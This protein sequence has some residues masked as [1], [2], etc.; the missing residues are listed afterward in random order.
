MGKAA[1]GQCRSASLTIKEKLPDTQAFIT[2]H[3][4]LKSTFKQVQKNIFP[5]KYAQLSF[6]FQIQ[7]GV[8]QIAQHSS[9]CTHSGASVMIL[10]N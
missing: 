2:K 7:V 6:P 3:E 9:T 8:P 1:L 10:N 5:F 4:K